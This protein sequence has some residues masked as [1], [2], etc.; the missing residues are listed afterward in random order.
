M[1]FFEVYVEVP[2]EVAE[3]RD[4]KGLYR[5]ARAG[6]IR[7]FTGIDQPYEAPESP[8]LVVHTASCSVQESAA[9]VIAMLDVQGLLEK[10]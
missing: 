8:E 7:G 4:P 2:L 1:P 5:K 9:A 3:S 6:K 10:G